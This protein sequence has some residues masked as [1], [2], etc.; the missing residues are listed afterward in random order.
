MGTVTLWVKRHISGQ[1]YRVVREE[2]K[3]D[4]SYRSLKVEL[5]DEE[6]EEDFDSY[7]PRINQRLGYGTIGE[8][9]WKIAVFQNAVSD[10]DR[11]IRAIVDIYEQGT[12]TDKDDKGKE[13]ASG[14]GPCS[15][16]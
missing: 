8:K 6:F 12:K 14:C 11:E 3:P 5:T 4:L 16:S 10:M 13:E 7:V 1:Y 15:I 2:P 9:L